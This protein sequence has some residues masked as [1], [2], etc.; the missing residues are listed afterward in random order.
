MGQFTS[1]SGSVSVVAAPTFRLTLTPRDIAVNKGD[2]DMVAKFTIGID[3]DATYI[4]PVYLSLAGIV[5][6][7]TITPNPVPADVSVSIMEIDM[8]G[9][10]VVEMPFEVY[11]FE[12]NPEG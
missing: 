8:T 7:E 2:T 10:G 3:R 4:K 1:V 5:G 9:Q 12:D 6:L 11:G